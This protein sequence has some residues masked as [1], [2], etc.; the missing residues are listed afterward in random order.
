MIPI[1]WLLQRLPSSLHTL[2]FSATKPRRIENVQSRIREAIAQALQPDRSS[3]VQRTGVIVTLRSV[4][5]MQVSRPNRFI[6][7][8]NIFF[9]L[10]RQQQL[11][12][13]LL[14]ANEI[15]W[16]FITVEQEATRVWGIGSWQSRLLMSAE[17]RAARHRHRGH[18]DRVGWQSRLLGFEQS[19]ALQV[20]AANT[21]GK[22]ALT[23]NELRNNDA[24]LSHQLTRAKCALRT[25]NFNCICCLCEAKPHA[26]L[27]ASIRT[28]CRVNKGYRSSGEIYFRI[29]FDDLLLCTRDSRHAWVTT[30][31]VFCWTVSYHGFF[32]W[33]GIN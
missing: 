16:E 31:W 12:N 5:P 1:H 20:P 25:I 8:H 22:H 13:K 4:H 6:N 21:T 9:A 30:N 7:Q 2:A 11:G 24:T 26:C 32:L 3:L 19:R 10:Q 23:D 28:A 27:E 14:N 33:V 29:S 15:K 17:E 18:Q